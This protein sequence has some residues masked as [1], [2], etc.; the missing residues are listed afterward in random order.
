MKSLK[1]ISKIRS[2]TVRVLNSKK[3]IKTVQ[4]FT[5]CKQNWF[6]SQK[7]VIQ[8]KNRFKS[9]NNAS[10]KTHVENYHKIE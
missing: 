7:V 8:L 10:L 4:I 1:N 6:K 2:Y 5:K 9:I 3:I